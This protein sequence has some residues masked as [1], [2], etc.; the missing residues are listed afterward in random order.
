MT[1]PIEPGSAR[2]KELVAQGILLDGQRN[3][4]LGDAALEIAPMGADGVNNGSAANLSLYADE[5]GVEYESLMQYRQ[6]ANAWPPSNRVLG[7]SWKV[8]QILVSPSRQK[9]IRENM[10]VRDARRAV[11]SYVEPSHIGASSDAQDKANLALQYLRDPDVARHVMDD[12]E[13]ARDLVE[14]N[15][16]AIVRAQQDRH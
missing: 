11:G 4:F 3:W 1:P 15:P 5:I 8:H 13:A 6:V 16:A 12:P 9:L 10:T 7:T 2:W 14:A